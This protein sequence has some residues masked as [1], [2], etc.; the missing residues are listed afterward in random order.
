MNFKNLRDKYLQPVLSWWQALESKRRR[1][2]MIAAGIFMAL[3]VAL[4]IFLNYQPYV[5]L[6]TNLSSAESSEILSRLQ[7]MGV[8]AKMESGG[9][10]L[11]P[12]NQEA[13][14]KMSLATEGYPKSGFSYDIYINNVGAMTTDS[15]RRAYRLF[16]LQER[17]QQ[18]VRTISGVTDAV[19]TISE[20]TAGSSVLTSSQTP[21]SASVLVTML[22]SE[23]LTAAQVNGIKQLVAKGVQGMSKEDVAVINSV[24]GNEM[25]A[26]ADSVSGRATDKMEI[27]KQIDT[28]IETKVRDILRPLLGEGYATVVAT[29]RVSTDAGVVQSV[30]YTPMNE[31]G[32][33]GVTASEEHY[34][35]GRNQEVLAAGAPGA[36]TN[37]DVPTYEELMNGEEGGYFVNKYDYDY[38]VNERKE[39]VER[40]DVVI[41]SIGVSV[42]IFSDVLT[43][44]DRVELTSLV[45]R[46]ANVPEDDVFIMMREYSS[47]PA[48]PSAV[49][50]LRTN[51]WIAVAAA[52]I[53]LIVAVII[54][55]LV[56]RR[57]QRRTMEEFERAAQE[58]ETARMRAETEIPIP[59]E[60]QQQKLSRQIKSFADEH[61]EIAAQL[62]RS[63]MKG[64]E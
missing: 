24:S 32:T 56:V 44:I 21:A 34:L 7:E 16:Q 15:D 30:T 61:P 64:D 55:V 5:N 31:D 50:Y 23:D 17:M 4:V 6:F 12:K 3:V 53:F 14:L 1:R 36:E 41:E 20:N 9:A 28:T 10:I 25:G 43:E 60:S 63:W 46:T 26:S 40:S 62:I 37:A 13:A 51:W 8:S 22:G 2:L 33:T 18:A 45:A 49:E 11:V 42:V 19:V 38:Y 59:E 57:R 39:Q 52:A 35:E 48:P 27:E 29:S 58:E 47:P 54:A